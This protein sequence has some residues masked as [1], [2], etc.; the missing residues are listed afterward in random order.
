MNKRTLYVRM[1][2][3]FFV[4]IICI[5]ITLLS[6]K[7]SP[8]LTYTWN[9]EYEGYVVDN[10]YGNAR[11][12]TVEDNYNGKPVVGIGLRA[13]YKHSKLEEVKFEKLEN[14]K[15]IDRFAFSECVNLKTINLEYVE[16]ID[17]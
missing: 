10:A 16:Y 11:T 3:P 6:F 1:L 12:Y 4:V 2:I 17:M 14:I 9:S 13:F 8:R 15:Y 7:Y 5:L